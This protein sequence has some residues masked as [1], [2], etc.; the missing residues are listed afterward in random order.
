M[1]PTI[2]PPFYRQGKWG[3][4]RLENLHEVIR[5]GWE[6]KHLDPKPALSLY[7]M[8]FTGPPNRNIT[9]CPKPNL[10]LIYHYSHQLIFGKLFSL[11]NDYYHANEILIP[12]SIPIIKWHYSTY[13]SEKTISKQMVYC[14]ASRIRHIP[15]KHFATFQPS[16][17]FA[18]HCAYS[19]KLLSV[20]SRARCPWISAK[21][22]CGPDSFQK[23]DVTALKVGAPLLAALL[24]RCYTISTQKWG[25]RKSRLPKIHSACSVGLWALKKCWQQCV[26]LEWTPSPPSPLPA[27]LCFWEGP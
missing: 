4:K 11:A 25:M 6:P 16:H 7:A 2:I 21:A 14:D 3:S 20:I 26:V 15:C 13:V 23:V 9:N 12:S 1:P 24:Q 17:M 5:P 22:R 19:K 8:N 18:H 10:L 27:W